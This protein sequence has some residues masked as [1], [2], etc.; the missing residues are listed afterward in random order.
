MAT[1]RFGEKQKT[2]EEIAAE[3]TR[4]ETEGGKG[5]QTVFYWGGSKDR[6]DEIAATYRYGR[7]QLPV[8]KDLIWF[9]GKAKMR[10]VHHELVMKYFLYKII[11]HLNR[12]AP[13]KPPPGTKTAYFAKAKSQAVQKEALIA[14]ALAEYRER[15]E[16][17]NRPA[18]RSEDLQPNGEEAM[19]K[20]RRRK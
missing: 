17:A 5:F 13:E 20:A 7:G 4:D 8:P 19:I 12:S 9:A 6:V 14:A 11:D 15:H 10:P 3:I 2:T 1:Q 16:Y 18:T